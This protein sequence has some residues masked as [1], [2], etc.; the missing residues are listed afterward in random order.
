M[1]PARVP[2]DLSFMPG[3]LC[4]ASGQ[5]GWLVVVVKTAVNFKTAV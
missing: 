1:V 2:L 4:V 5:W 3:A